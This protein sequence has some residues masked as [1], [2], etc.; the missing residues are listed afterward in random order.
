MSCL[1]RCISIAHLSR[2][3]EFSVERAAGRYEALLFGD[4]DAGPNSTSR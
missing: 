1:R 4:V 2:V 3:A